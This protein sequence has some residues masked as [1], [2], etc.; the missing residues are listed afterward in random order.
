MLIDQEDLPFTRDGIVPDI[1]FN[2][3][4]IPSHL[5]EVSGKL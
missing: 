1:L 5:S 4:G 2:G 3:H